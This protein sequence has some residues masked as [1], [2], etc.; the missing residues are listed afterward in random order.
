MRVIKEVVGNRWMIKEARSLLSVVSKVISFEHRF[1]FEVCFCDE[2]WLSVARINKL[3][4]MM[5]I[6][7]TP[8]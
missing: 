7:R 4:I 6:A 5:V 8:L 3:L 2:V 1:I